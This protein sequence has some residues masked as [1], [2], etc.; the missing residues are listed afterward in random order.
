MKKTVLILG[1]LILMGAGCATSVTKETQKEPTAKA[2]VEAKAQRIEMT[3]NGFN[4]AQITVPVGTTVKFVNNDE[5]ERWPASGVHPTHQ[6]CPGFDSLKPMAPGESYEFTFKE[7]KIC[8]MH[9]HL[10]PVLKGVIKV[11]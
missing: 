9:D 4:P 10:N 2:P 6:L 5:T 1:S 3:A 8:P 7:A 11:E